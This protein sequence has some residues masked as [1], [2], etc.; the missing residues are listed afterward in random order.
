MSLDGMSLK[1][2]RKLLDSIK[3]K[4]ELVLSKNRDSEIITNGNSHEKNGNS[5]IIQNQNGDSKK[6][7]ND[8][9]QPKEDGKKC[10]VL[11]IFRFWFLVTFGDEVTK[12]LRNHCLHFVRQDGQ[13]GK[14]G[15]KI[16]QL[17][18]P[19][20]QKSKDENIKY[21]MNET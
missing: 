14:N 17:K 20:Y 8:S 6:E 11:P 7:N 4:L 19:K 16:T 13:D 12:I 3:E 10:F 2:A 21:E 18:W 15:K 5:T 9:Q 1:E